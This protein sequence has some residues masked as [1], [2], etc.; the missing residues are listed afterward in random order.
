V[1]DLDVI[2]TSPQAAHDACEEAWRIVKGLTLCGKPVRIVAGEYDRDRSLE[3]NRFYWGPLLGAISDQ[4]RTPDKW[5]AEAWHQLFRR[6]FLGFKIEKQVVAGKKKPVIIRRLR[7]TRDLTVK[8]FAEYVEKITA[9]AV[10]ELGVV[11]P[12]S[13]T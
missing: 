3:Q 13:T 11:F 7:S 2:A 1:A 8:Q 9:Y 12:E 5:T 10:T 4:V 6:Q